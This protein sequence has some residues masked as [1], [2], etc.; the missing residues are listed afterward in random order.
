[1]K[2]D[3]FSLKGRGGFVRRA[4]PLVDRASKCWMLGLSNEVYD[5]SVLH[6]VLDIR[7]IKV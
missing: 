2:L 3:L 6:V 5:F 4:R 1:M 7:D